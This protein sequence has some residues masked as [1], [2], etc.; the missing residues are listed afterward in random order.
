MKRMNEF[1]KKKVAVCASSY[2]WQNFSMD[3]KELA[4]KGL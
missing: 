1:K 3:I 4:K 2:G